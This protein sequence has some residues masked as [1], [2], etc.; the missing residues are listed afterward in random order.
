MRIVVGISGASGAI[1]GI[2]ILEVLKKIG[3]DTDLVMSDSAKRTIVYETDYSINDVKRLASC[4]HDIND[5]GASIASG[6]FRH[7]GMIIAP[8]SI[9]TLSAVANSFNTNLLI[10]AAD[11]T[12]KERRK[13]VLM[14][15]ETPLHLG[16]LRLMTQVTET[17]AVLVPPLPAFYHRPKTLDDIINQSVTK[18]LDQFDLDVDLFGRWTGNEEREHAKARSD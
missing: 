18:V 8:C 12:L 17:G 13:L 2:R 3:V 10:R 7:A 15:R 16:H 1:Y 6:S 11:V 14:I 9:K 4:V 5:V